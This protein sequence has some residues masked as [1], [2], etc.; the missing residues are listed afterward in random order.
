MYFVIL[1][2]EN[3]NCMNFWLVSHEADNQL[4][5]RVSLL[6]SIQAHLAKITV[7]YM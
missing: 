3:L 4:E 1:L 5:G 7:V 2:V 6:P